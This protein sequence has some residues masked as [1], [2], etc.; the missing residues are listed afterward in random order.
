MVKN[1]ITISF[2]ILFLIGFG[3]KDK[4]PLNPDILP[5]ET[6]VSIIV[7]I[8]LVQAAFK[9]E[10]KEKKF[11]IDNVSN[12]IFKDNHTTKKQ[13]DESMVYYSKHPQEVESIYNDVISTLSQKQVVLK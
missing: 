3:C 2:L 8:E 9:I 6:M 10:N 12:I 13:F 4:T 11:N 1:R 5:K 7:D